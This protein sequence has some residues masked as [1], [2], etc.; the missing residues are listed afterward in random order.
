M[1]NLRDLMPN[2]YT[3]ASR[4]M[5]LLVRLYEL[6]LNYVKTNSDTLGTLP[7]SNSDANITAALART[8]GFDTKRAYTQKQLEAIVD[9]FPTLIRCKGTLKAINLAGGVITKAEHASDSF[10]SELRLLKKPIAV[11]YARE[12]PYEIQTY[13]LAA[14]IPEEVKDITLFL[15]VLPYIAPAG[16]PICVERTTHQNKLSI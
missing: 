5:Q 10:N 14:M 13:E 11:D 6:V 16:V 2:V 12:A 7:G 1:L 4:D 3:D 15:D 9:I 8:L